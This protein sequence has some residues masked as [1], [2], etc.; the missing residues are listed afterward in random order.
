MTYSQPS[1]RYARPHAEIV[2]LVLHAVILC[3]YC[4][5]AW[6]LARVPEGWIQ[7]GDALRPP[8]R[9]AVREVISVLVFRHTLAGAARTGTRSFR[10]SPAPD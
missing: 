2:T 7:A 10:N 9:V 4:E 8:R 5:P 1:H 6:F 3:S